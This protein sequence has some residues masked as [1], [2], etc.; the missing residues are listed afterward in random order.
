MATQLQ[1]FSTFEAVHTLEQQGPLDDS[2]AMPVAFHASTDRQQRLLDRA[3]LLG[4]RLGMPQQWQQGKQGL[5]IAVLVFALAMLVSA[6]GLAQAIVGPEKHINAMA[7]FITILGVHGVM[8]LVWL[9]GV[10]L[11]HKSGDGASSWSLGALALRL[12]SKLSLTKGPQSAA[13]ADGLMHVLRRQRLLLWAFGAISHSIWALYFVLVLLALWFGFSFHAYTLSWE[14]TILSDSFFVR[15]VQSTAWAVAKLGIPT[16][17]V[18]QIVA[19]GHSGA[20]MAQSDWAWWLMGCA[21]V[22]GLL[23]RIVLALVCWL[24]WQARTRSLSLDFGTPAARRL[25]A[26][27]DAMQPTQVVDA[28]HAVAEPVAPTMAPAAHLGAPAML[29]F[30]L[31]PETPWPPAGIITA[32]LWLQSISGSSQERSALMQVLV[33]QRP[34]HLLVVLAA[35]HSP[36]RGTARYLQQVAATAQRTALYLVS[37]AGLVPQQQSQWQDWLNAHQLAWPLLTRN[38]QANQWLSGQ[39][40]THEA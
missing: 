22:Y 36:D 11:P 23:P 40:P 32:G 30:E 1:R 17:N 28:E 31:P 38:T 13:L 27:F 6:W 26:R 20:A 24:V 29:G 12:S 33:S 9:V 21:L 18:E 4:E 25:L 35:S 14:T 39:E 8:L 19:A 15:F 3:W 2:A 7:A 10:L 34:Q 37:E 16:P 5:K